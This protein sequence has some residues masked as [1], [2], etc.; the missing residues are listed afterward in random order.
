LKFTF[1]GATADE[2][3]L[4]KTELDAR[5]LK[6][7]SGELWTPTPT[8][9]YGLPVFPSITAPPNAVTRP[10][11]NVPLLFDLVLMKVF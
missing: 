9:N 11:K 1:R 8:P 6:A 5:Y 7:L 2:A 4:W 10:P 3:T